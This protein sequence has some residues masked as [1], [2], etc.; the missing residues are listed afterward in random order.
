M[1]T[2]VDVFEMCREYNLYMNIQ[3]RGKHAYLYAGRNDGKKCASKIFYFYVC[4]RRLFDTLTP[5]TF[6][7]MLEEKYRFHLAK[8]H[9]SFRTMCATDGCL[10]EGREECQY[11]IQVHV[12]IRVYFCQTCLDQ[13]EGV[14]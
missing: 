5:Q 14:A 11:V 7:T 6:R 12:A 10:R 13:I 2:D 9:V 1:I 4:P 8:R 3:Q